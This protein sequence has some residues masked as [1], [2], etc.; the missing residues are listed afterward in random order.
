M[1]AVAIAARMRSGTPGGSGAIGDKGRDFFLNLRRA[2][3]RAR[4]DAL[5]HSAQFFKITLAGF[6][7]EFINRHFNHHIYLNSLII[8]NNKII[9]YLTIVPRLPLAKPAA[10][11]S[12]V[13]R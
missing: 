5:T 7:A 2:A 10:F 12:S 1:S 3:K 13:S 4:I 11:A 8:N 9:T 6:T